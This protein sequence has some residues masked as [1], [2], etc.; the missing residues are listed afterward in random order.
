[1]G[2]PARRSPE[3]GPGRGRGADQGQPRRPQLRRHAPARGLVPRARRAAARAGRRG[4]R[5]A[6]RERRAGGGA[7]RVRGLRGVCDR[8]GGAGAARAPPPEGLR[9]R[10]REANDG[11][12]VDIVLEMAGGEVFEQSLLALARFGRLVSYGIASGEQNEVPTGK[13][14]RCSRAVVGFWLM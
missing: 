5:R 4:R 1:R 7:V 14:M 12:K 2:A 9:E 6:R 13:L 11:E 10:I 8:A 3:A